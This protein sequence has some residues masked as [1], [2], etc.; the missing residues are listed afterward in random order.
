MTERSDGAAGIGGRRV[1]AGLDAQGRATVLSSG[2]PPCSMD[3]HGVAIEELWRFESPPAGPTDGGDPSP[4][5]WQLNARDPGGF[6]WRIVRFATSSPELHVTPT[7]D[8]VVVVDGR[9]DLLLEDGPVRL[10]RYDSAVIQQCMHG[11]SLVD[12]EPCTMLA[13]MIT[14][15][16]R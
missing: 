8:L 9:I 2:P 16:E 7:I 13:A 5:A 12:D 6:A 11:W 3:M 14:M 4:D 15:P 1:V 10:E